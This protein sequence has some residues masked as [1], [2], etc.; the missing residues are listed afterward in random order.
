MKKN[1][2][3]VVLVVEIAAISILHTVKIKQ[4][5]KNTQSAIASRFSPIKPALKVKSDYILAKVVK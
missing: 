2:S 4:S 1:I 5:E 3:L